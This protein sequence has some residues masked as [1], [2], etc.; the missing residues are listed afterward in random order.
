MS[1]GRN[2]IGAQSPHVERC[3]V[4][5]MEKILPLM[6]YYSQ[7]DSVNCEIHVIVRIFSICVKDHQH[8]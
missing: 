1:L 2:L 5:Q 7:L 6:I 4:L 8:T 3:L